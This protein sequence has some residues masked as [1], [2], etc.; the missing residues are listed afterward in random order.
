MVNDPQSAQVRGSRK[1]VAGEREGRRKTVFRTAAATVA[2]GA[3]LLLA[4][5]LFIIFSGTYNVAAT[6]GHT[7]PV[8]WALRTTMENSVRN[9][10]ADVEV[11]ENIDM[12]DPAF[13]GQFYGHYTACVTCHA[14][15]GTEADPWMINYPP[16]PNL[17]QA[18]IISRW[19]EEEM[20]WIVKNGIKD[21]AMIALGPTHEDRDI[22]GV[23]AFA[24]QLPRMSPERFE[25]FKRQYE[26]EQQAQGNSGMGMGGGPTE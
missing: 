5:G 7:G 12:E 17:T 21:T 14:A 25:E 3:L 26:A 22:W 18:S 2:A 9:H 23:V 6:D 11:P 4:G 13:Y 19:S 24:R 20:F 10:A 1:P 15:P 16:A 8:A